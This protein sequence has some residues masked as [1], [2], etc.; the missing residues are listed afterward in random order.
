MQQN[1]TSEYFLGIRL[2]FFRQPENLITEISA[3]L[4]I[5][6]VKLL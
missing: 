6:A 5:K 3:L 1:E 2:L 4:L